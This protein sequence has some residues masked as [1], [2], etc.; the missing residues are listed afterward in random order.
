MPKVSVNI[1]TKNRAELLKKALLSVVNQSFKDFELIVV[2]DGSTDETEKVLNDL[3]IERY[4]AKGGSAFGGKDLKI[5]THGESIGITKSRQE[6]LE[7]ST[8]KYIAILDDD[9]EWIDPEK[10]KKQVD[11][12]DSHKDCV[13]VGAAVNLKI[14]R[15]KDLKIT[16]RPETDARIRRT[17]LLRNNFF[18]STVMF[19][20]EAAITAGG[21]VSDTDDFVEDYDLWLRM[22]KLGQMYNFPQVFTCYRVPN[23]NKARFKA[24]LAKQVILA[25]RNK[26]NYPFVWLAVAILRLRIFL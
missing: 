11:Y 24:F 20:R 16:K 8:G 12:L 22:G 3:K 10:L 26:S 14:E 9:D 1:L 19:K 15:L 2:N 6:A 25:K 4:S 7:K 23:Y 21:F 13:L 17:M 5:I 18:T